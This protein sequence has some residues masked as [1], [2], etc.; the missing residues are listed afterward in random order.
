M[1]TIHLIVLPLFM[2]VCKSAQLEL[3]EIVFVLYAQELFHTPLG[4]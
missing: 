1:S 4:V 3:S 2:N